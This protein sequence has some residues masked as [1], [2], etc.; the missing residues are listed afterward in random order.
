[1]V[2]VAGGI[3]FL[4][5]SN[6]KAP[7]NSLTNNPPINAPLANTNSSIG[8]PQPHS[9]EISGFAFNPNTLTVKVGDTVTWTNKDSM[10]HTVT[11]DSGSELSSST[12][13]NGQT[14]SHTFST[15]GTFA[16]HCTI[17]TSMKANIVVE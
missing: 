11:S 13:S 15:A 9:V 6:Y 2:I 8:T 12:L 17:H 4:T 10:G 16:Y 5:M 14:Y 1:V 3:Y 7:A